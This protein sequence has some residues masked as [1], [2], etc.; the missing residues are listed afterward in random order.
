M[1][2]RRRP[3]ESDQARLLRVSKFLSKHLRHEP[4]RLGLAPGGWVGVIIGLVALGA[5]LSRGLARVL[6]AV[7]LAGR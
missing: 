6:R 2:G 4:G 5:H 7:E 3:T 1:S